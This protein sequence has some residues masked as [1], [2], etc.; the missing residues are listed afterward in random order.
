MLTD[1]IGDMLTRIRNANEARHEKV[2]IP[3][4]RM[5]E[6]IATILKSEGFIKD[7][8]IG[9]EGVK[10]SLQIE[11]KY[12]GDGHRV[13]NH[14]ERISTPGRR[15]YVAKKDIPKVLSGL[16]VSIITTSRGVMTGHKA[17]VINVGGEYVCRIW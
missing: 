6:S 15:V 14:I 12:A 4:S 13:I 10:K 8:G 1:S 17:R 3:Y 2:A 11:L 7:Y 5:K 16:G 9:D